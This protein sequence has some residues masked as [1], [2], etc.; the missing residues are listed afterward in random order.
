MLA[1]LLAA[2]AVFIGTQPRL[3]APFGL[4]RNGLIAYDA[5]GD[6]YAADPVTGAATAIVSGP[7]TDVAPY[8]SRDGSRIVFQRQVGDLLVQLYVVGVDGSDLTLVT[9]EP[10]ALTASLLGEPAHAY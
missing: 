6:I 1:L 4:A 8:Y 3:P 5:G 9:P 7:E 10:V 2:T